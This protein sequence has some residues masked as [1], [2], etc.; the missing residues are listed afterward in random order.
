MKL[1]PNPTTANNQPTRAK[2]YL[3]QEQ[4]LSVTWVGNGSCPDIEN[5]FQKKR[6]T[7]SAKVIFLTKKIVFLTEKN[8]ILD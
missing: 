8:H 6:K 1:P 2:T 7:P 4:N 5:A 3:I